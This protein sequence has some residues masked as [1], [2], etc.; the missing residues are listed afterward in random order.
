MQRTGVHVFT[1]RV[2]Q[3]AT[4]SFAIVHLDIQNS[5]A[6]FFISSRSLGATLSWWIPVWPFGNVVGL[7]QLNFRTA[8]ANKAYPLLVERLSFI[9]R[10]AKFSCVCLTLPFIFLNRG[11]RARVVAIGSDTTTTHLSV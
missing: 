3:D 10:I 4:I 9:K 2:I 6:S 5:R 8:T 11:V 1:R 7:I